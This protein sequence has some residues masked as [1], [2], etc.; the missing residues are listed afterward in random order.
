MPLSEPR[1]F[2]RKC[3][4]FIGASDAPE[5]EQVLLCAAFPDGKGIPYS[6]AFGEEL[7]V[8]PVQGDHGIQYEEETGVFP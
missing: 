3:K 5:T 8:L 2:A 6:I 7:H 1:C 4:H